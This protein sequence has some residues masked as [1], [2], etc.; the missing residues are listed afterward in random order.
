MNSF[1]G[2]MS[3]IICRKEVYLRHNTNIPHVLCSSSGWTRI[4]P[5]NPRRAT[6]ERKLSISWSPNASLEGE[7]I[8]QM[9]KYLSDEIIFISMLEVLYKY[10]LD[11]KR[12]SRIYFSV[13]H[14]KGNDENNFDHSLLINVR[15]N[16]EF[17][18]HLSHDTSCHVWRSVFCFPSVHCLR[19]SM[20][21]ARPVQV[22]SG[23]WCT[24]ATLPASGSGAWPGAGGSLW[25]WSCCGCCHRAEAEIHSQGCSWPGWWRSNTVSPVIMAK[26]GPPWPPASSLMAAVT[27]EH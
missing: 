7:I 11:L 20:A 3:S 13:L 21:R 15:I 16:N 27:S 8:T 5:R 24:L 25:L 17:I 19:Q 2:L 4:Q 18:W 6:G 10:P 9:L 14:G 1:R 26:T 23:L 22:G 12:D